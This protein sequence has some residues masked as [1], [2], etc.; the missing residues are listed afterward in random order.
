PAGGVPAYEYL[1]QAIADVSQ[2][3]EMQLSE[4]SSARAAL[5]AVFDDVDAEIV[6]RIEA[7]KHVSGKAMRPG[8]GSNG[9]TFDEKTTVKKLKARRLKHTDIYPPKLASPAQIL[10]H[11]DLTE[12]QKTRLEKDLVT[13]T[14]G[15]LK[16]T[17]VAHTE[18]PTESKVELMFG[19]LAAPAVATADVPLSF[20]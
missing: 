18:A 2:L 14:A 1:G 7:G 5:N 20:F 11:P 10:K 12:A 15:K 8:Q 6:T 3:T 4:L 16:L 19:D 13:Y 17:D 9:W